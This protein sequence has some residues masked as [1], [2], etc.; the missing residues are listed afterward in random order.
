MLWARIEAAGEPFE[1]PPAEAAERAR[2]WAEETLVD[3]LALDDVGSPGCDRRRC[4]P[5]SWSLSS[6]ADIGSDGDALRAGP[7][8][9]RGLGGRVRTICS[10]AAARARVPPEASVHFEIKDYRRG[11]LADPVERGEL[12]VS[13]RRRRGATTRLMIG[14]GIER[15]L[16]LSATAS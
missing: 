15:S 13:R 12:E 10:S 16:T 4:S 5:T 14:T 3:A 11:L 1:T 2:E 9:G 8:A 7:L 6:T